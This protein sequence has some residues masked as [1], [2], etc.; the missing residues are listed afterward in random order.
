MGGAGDFSFVHLNGQRVT[1]L[2][3]TLTLIGPNSYPV[4]VLAED[5]VVACR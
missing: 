5:V 3:S 4:Y 1:Y 2:I